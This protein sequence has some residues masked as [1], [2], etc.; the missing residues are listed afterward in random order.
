MKQLSGMDAPAGRC[1]SILG[2]AAAAA[3]TTDAT[4][5]TDA[6][7]GLH[8]CHPIARFRAQRLANIRG[9]ALCITYNIV[10]IV[11]DV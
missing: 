8:T 4:D 1:F 7:T 5:A 11:L 10:K 6:G 2:P 9:H 3:V